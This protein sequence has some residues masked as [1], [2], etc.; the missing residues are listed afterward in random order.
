M[1]QRWGAGLEETWGWDGGGGG[2]AGRTEQK[3]HEAGGSGAHRIGMGDW[4]KGGHEV[5]S[6]AN[7]KT[8]ISVRAYQH[9][10]HSKRGQSLK[11]L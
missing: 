3:G 11:L 7:T 2:E 1:V 4:G 6:P 10:N 5:M 8:L 9:N